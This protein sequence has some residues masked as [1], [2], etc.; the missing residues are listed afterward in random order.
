MP[1]PGHHFP[2]VCKCIKNT[3]TLWKNQ[4]CETGHSV[5]WGMKLDPATQ[6]NSLSPSPGKGCRD[7]ARQVPNP[8]PVL[9]QSIKESFH[10]APKCAIPPPKQSWQT[11][12]MMGQQK[13][14][15]WEKKYISNG[16]RFFLL[17]HGPNF[18]GYVAYCQTL[19]S[20]DRLY[21]NPRPSTGITSLFEP[22]HHPH[23]RQS[24]Q[25]ASSESSWEHRAH[26]ARPLL[27]PALVSGRGQKA[28]RAERVRCLLAGSLHSH[29]PTATPLAAQAA[30]LG[31]T[32]WKRWLLGKLTPEDICTFFFLFCS[33]I[34]SSRAEPVNSQ[35]S[36]PFEPAGITVIK[37]NPENLFAQSSAWIYIKTWCHY[38]KQLPNSSACI[39]RSHK[40]TDCKRNLGK[41]D[42]WPKAR[43]ES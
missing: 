29:S 26:R 1:E 5:E 11:P 31:K 4:S 18:S 3:S 22:L 39:S 23:V 36:T 6:R 35:G 12:P 42:R 33:S 16:N 37:V 10:E 9:P 13:L 20:A 15:V 8:P 14:E 2:L 43:L 7:A 21:R 28:T 30:G 17:N 27:L 24:L 41:S 19:L 32:E 34:K 25:E 38:W 40:L